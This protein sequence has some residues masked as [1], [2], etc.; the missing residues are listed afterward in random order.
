M[1]WLLGPIAVG[2]VALIVSSLSE[3][4]KK[5]RERWQSKREE[6]E[7]TVE[8][9]RKNIE[10]HIAS[11]QQ[12]YDFYVLVDIHYSSHKIADSAYELL[13]DARRSITTIKNILNNVT[14]K[15]NE[16]KLSIDVSKPDNKKA[17][18]AEIRSLNEFKS[19]IIGDLSTLK[20][21]RDNFLAEV[22]RLNAQTAILKLAIR[23]RCGEKGRD[24]FDRLEYRSNARKE[25]E[26]QT[27][28]W[29][30]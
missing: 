9:H 2:A 22:Q 19:T 18:L 17:I 3:D 15:K 11:A 8:C 10:E 7:K 14:L 5:A 26:K 13:K 1:W 24:W 25:Q 30:F 12:S 29:S 20:T 28:K 16:L 27:I 23:D 4:E 21:Q 6:V